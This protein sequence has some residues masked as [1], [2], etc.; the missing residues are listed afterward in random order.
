MTSIP[1]LIGP[2]LKSFLVFIEETDALKA[3]YQK[4]KIYTYNLSLPLY[5]SLSNENETM[6]VVITM[7]AGTVNAGIVAFIIN[8]GI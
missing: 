7:I 4:K 2:K 3:N 1:L 8:L 5:R 6:S